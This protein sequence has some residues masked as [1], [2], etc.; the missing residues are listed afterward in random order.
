VTQYSRLAGVY[1]WLVPEEL[2]TP[3]G[4]V[5]AYDGLYELAPGSRVLDCAAGTGTLAVGLALR[6]HAVTAT[7]ASEAMIERTRTLAARRGVELP[8]RVCSW[9]E[10]TG[11]PTFDAVFCIGHAITHAQGRAG[12]RAAL[13]AMAGVLGDGGLLVLS[14]R[15]WELVR[16]AGS[17]LRVAERLVERDGGRALLVHGWTHADDW[18]QRSF[19]DVAVALIDDA[20]GVTTHAERLTFWPFRHKDL[21]AD[22]RAA[23]L[24]LSSSTYAPDVERYFVSARA[25]A[26]RSRA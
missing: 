5:A 21:E 20:G 25:P 18:D 3:E 10:L 2:L 17:G 12:R 26:P 22:L 1:D 24:E 16:A 9:E 23:G 11:P 8:T 19:L 15:N 13:R 6:G 7:D 14:S 4:C